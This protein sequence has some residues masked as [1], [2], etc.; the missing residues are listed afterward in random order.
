MPDNMTTEQVDLRKHLG[1]AEVKAEEV[2]KRRAAFL[3]TGFSG[4]WIDTLQELR[5]TLFAPEVLHAHLIG[6][7]ERGFSNPNK[8]IESSPAILGL[9]FENIDRRLNM[10]NKL[11]SH[12]RLELSAVEL[13]E[14]NYFLFSSKIAKLWVLARTASEFNLKPD[15]V[16]AKLVRSL[17]GSNLEDVLVALKAEHSGEDIEGF[18]RRVRAVKAQK[19]PKEEKRQ[20]IADE[21]EGFEKIKRRYF[22]GY[23]EAA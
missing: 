12:Y 7:K 23:P 17:V 18:M 14:G 13:M 21:L 19:I 15:D 9:A 4:S 11:I 3:G 22:R 16:N 10:F 1:E 6:L 8:M 5:P 20:I 2:A